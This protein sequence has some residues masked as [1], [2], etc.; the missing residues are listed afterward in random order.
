M[1][2][3]TSSLDLDGMIKTA[4]FYE[5]ARGGNNG[6]PRNDGLRLLDQTWRAHPDNTEEAILVGR[7]SVKQ[8]HAED[9]TGNVA[10]AS[11]LW[12]GALP[13]PGAERPKLDG[14][15]RQETFIRVFIPIQPR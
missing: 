9:V 8:G 15:M 6:S 2:T 5:A 3:T 14:L 7:L 4:F 10:S 11:L 13:A 1:V 12:L